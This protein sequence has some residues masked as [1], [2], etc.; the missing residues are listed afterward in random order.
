MHVRALS[1]GQTAA[2]GVAEAVFFLCCVSFPRSSCHRCCPPAVGE[3]GAKGSRGGAS[4]RR[5]RGREAR[6]RG[7]G[8]ALRNKGEAARV[9]CVPSG[10]WL[11]AGGQQGAGG[12]GLARM[13][14]P[15]GAPRRCCAADRHSARL[16]AARPYGLRAG[17]RWPWRPRDELAVQ[18]P[19]KKGRERPQLMTAGH[20]YSSPRPPTPRARAPPCSDRAAGQGP[21]CRAQED[22]GINHVAAASCSRDCHVSLVFVTDSLSWGVSSDER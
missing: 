18:P 2:L 21:N 7:H 5:R 15:L 6:G 13:P 19:P 9:R 16:V 12:G 11:Q 14:P 22:S 1:S 8:S 10:S 3:G 4:G 20:P 17:M